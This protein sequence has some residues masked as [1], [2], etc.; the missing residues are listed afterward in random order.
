[1]GLPN[2]ACTT[3]AQ[4]NIDTPHFAVTRGRERRI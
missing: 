3:L 1:M 2:A 4:F